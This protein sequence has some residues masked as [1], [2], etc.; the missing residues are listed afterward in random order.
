MLPR[1]FQHL[2]KTMVASGIQ[3]RRQQNS[4]LITSYHITKPLETT[5][6]L[7]Q[8]V[9]LVILLRAKQREQMQ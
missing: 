7:Q 1:S 8:Q 2:W 5:L 3:M 4:T 9:L 6:F